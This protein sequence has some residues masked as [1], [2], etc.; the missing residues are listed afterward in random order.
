MIAVTLNDYGITFRNSPEALGGLTFENT[1]GYAYGILAG[2]QA[3][4][5]PALDRAQASGALAR[6]CPCQV[7]ADVSRRCLRCGKNAPTDVGGYALSA[8]RA[9]YPG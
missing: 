2:Q 9:G 3:S 6:T 5:Q 7:A 8:N 4:N 1:Q